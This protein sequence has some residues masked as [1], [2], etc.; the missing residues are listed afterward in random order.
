TLGPDHPN[1]LTTLHHAAAACAAA[2]RPGEAV[3]RYAEALAGRKAQLGDGHPDALSSADALARLLVTSADEKVRDP[4]RA[5]ALATTVVRLAPAVGHHSNTLGAAHYRAGDFRSALAALDRS[6]ALR[7]G[8]DGYDWVLLA[9]AH[10]RAG[11]RDEGRKWYDRAAAAGHR[12][13]TTELRLLLAE[14]AA[15]FEGEDDDD[16]D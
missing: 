11:A 8:G 13:L 14:A 10:R 2:G 9:M 12:P 3:K 16:D 6:V 1:R 5:V 15:L 4:G 7:G